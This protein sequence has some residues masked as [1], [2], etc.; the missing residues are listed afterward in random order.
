[1][2]VT[3]TIGLCVTAILLW[4][5]EKKKETP[6]GYTF[7][8]VSPGDGKTVKPGDIL[9]IDMAIVDQNDSAWYDNRQSD[10]P[11]VIRVTD[12]SKMET[13][14]GIAEV[15][16][17]LSK[18]DS[19]AFP[20]RAKDVFLFMWRMDVPPGVDPESTFTYQVKCRDVLD[21]AGAREF[22]NTRD[23]IHN[24]KENARTAKEEELQSVTDAELAAYNEVQLGK[25]TL[26]IDNYLKSKNVKANSLPSGIR[27]I[28]KSKG[29]GPSPENGDIVNMKYHG[30]LLDGTEFDSG[31]YTFGVGNGDVIKGWDDIALS[32]KKGTV[33]TVFIP[34]TLAYQ[35]AGRAPRIMPDAIL[36]FDMELLSFRKP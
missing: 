34:S 36:V 18:G 22:V 3:A 19:V 7:T 24:A 2:K 30:Q 28:I 13:E 15:F 8:V 33:V 10:Y 1:M 12:V 5:C 11:E 25:D 16:R 9:I 20:M 26:I 21:E 32:M 35:K 14:R 27:Y 17:M 29:E 31:E 6:M 4:S 23:S